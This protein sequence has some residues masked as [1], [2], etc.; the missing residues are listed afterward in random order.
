MDSYLLCIAVVVFGGVISLL[1]PGR[2]KSYSVSLS[3]GISAVIIL[4]VSFQ[5]IRYNEPLI[6]RFI[7]QPPFG[8]VDMVIDS[9]SAFFI[10]VIS[11]VSFLGSL[12]TAGYMAPYYGSDRTVTSHFFF[13]SLL[14]AAMLLVPVV[15][16]ALAFLMVWEIMSLSSFFLVVFENEKEDVVK[17]GINYLVSMHIGVIFLICAFLLLINRSGSMDFSSFPSVLKNNRELSTVI[18]FLFFTGF[19]TKAGFIPFHTWLPRAHP[20]APGHISG[21]MSG[22]MIKTGIYGILRMITFIPEKTLVMGY[23]V[24]GISLASGILGVAYAIA[25]HNV[26]RLL[27]YSS[28]E[29]IGIIGTGIGIGLLGSVYDNRALLVMGNTGALLHILNHSLFKPLLFFSAGGVCQKTR[30]LNINR[31]GGIIKKMK[32]SGAFFL[33]GSLAIAGLPPFNGFVSEFIIYRGFLSGMEGT[34]IPLVVSL[35]LAFAGFALTGVLALFCFSR[36][37]GIMFL[38]HPR[39]GYPGMTG[40]VSGIMKLSM[41]LLSVPIVII[42][43]LP[44]EV[45]RVISG[46]AGTIDLS[47]DPGASAPF[48]KSMGNLTVIIWIFIGITGLIFLLRSLLL[49]RRKVETFKTWD[50]GY[51]GGNSRMQYTGSSFSEHFIS[52]NRIFFKV[53]EKVSS[54]EGLFPEKGEFESH[55]GDKLETLVILPGTALVRKFLNRFSWIQSGNT[56]Q[57]IL[58]GLVSLLIILAWITGV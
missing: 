1:L 25:Q 28:V 8:G 49:R 33:T 21:L 43:I 12:Y 53:N 38:G 17:A 57:Y 51:R 27:A 13:L 46:I 16:N 11:A 34:S 47:G 41:I 20:A 56:Q 35:I 19:G 10:S 23:T 40:D 15:Q 44:G 24:L 31:M 58:Y 32:F 48:L 42:G 2:Y 3:T 7:L 45:F 52:L 55:I 22:V 18:F 4:Q 6:A 9:L 14:M 36:V 50:C 30:T 29:N 39:S 37:F 5:V 26:K 54:P